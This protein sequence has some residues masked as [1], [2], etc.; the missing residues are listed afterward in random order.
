MKELSLNILDVAENSVKADATLIQI[1]LKETTEELCLTIKDNGC[2]MTQDVVKG[3]IDP[4]YTTRTTR[5]VGLGIPLLKMAAEQTGG[6]LSICSR[7]ISEDP[8]NP[9]RWEVPRN[10]KILSTDR[11]ACRPVRQCLL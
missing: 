2:G 6:K 5:K 10:R 11:P 9:G 1:E 3:V 8:E 7:H 4:F